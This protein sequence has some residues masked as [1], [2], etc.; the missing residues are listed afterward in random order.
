M[1]VLNETEP[2]MMGVSGKMPNSSVRVDSDDGPGKTGTGNLVMNER[3][4]RASDSQIRQTSVFIGI[5][6]RQ[7]KREALM[8]VIR[9]GNGM[10]V[11]SLYCERRESNLITSLN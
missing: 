2:K 10:V 9:Y 4:C 1:L 8:V 7:M 3:E 11:S 5:I 6:E